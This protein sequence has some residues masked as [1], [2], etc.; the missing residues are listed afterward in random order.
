MRVIS[1]IK[2]KG[3]TGASTIAQS[4]AV[5]AKLAGKSVAIIDLDPQAT[6]CK[7]GDRRNDDL[8]I[9]SIQPARLKKAL[10]DARGDGADLVIIDTPPRA[11]DA[12]M[13]AA[14]AADLILIPTRPT[15][16]DLETLG[17]TKTLIAG[18]GAKAKIAVLLNGVPAQGPQTE[19]AKA[20]ISDLGL[21]VLSVTLGNRSAY[22]H[23][24][25]LGKTAQEYD[26]RGKAAE[27]IKQLY[28]FTSKLLNSL[29]PQKEIRHA[30]AAR[31]A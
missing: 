15:I 6:T 25:I 3:G 4:L 28:K 8:V 12:A 19:Q 23:A 30:K 17:T 2:Q 10:D 16:N 7:W 18:A 9:V 22:T 20:Y 1:L 11:S 26:P 29:T 27:E 5:A 21:P 14:Q 13:A 24:A 31:T